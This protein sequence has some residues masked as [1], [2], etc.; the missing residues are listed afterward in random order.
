MDG[1]RGLSLYLPKIVQYNVRYRIHLREH[2]FESLLKRLADEAPALAGENEAMESLRDWWLREK[3]LASYDIQCY[4]I[5]D[6]ITVLGH[7]FDGLSDVVKH[8]AMCGREFYTGF[9]SWTQTGNDRSAEV[10]VGKIYLNYPVFDSFDLRD[11][12]TYQN[13]LFRRFPITSADMED[14]FKTPR[15]ANF[16]MVHERIPKD[17]LPLLYYRGDGGYMLLAA[18]HI[19]G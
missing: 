12:R 1:S 11:D 19:V 15:M 13:Y 16:C 7:E 6:K 8:T 4:N 5:K 18:E 3:R 10:S 2:G 9:E 17:K 14:V